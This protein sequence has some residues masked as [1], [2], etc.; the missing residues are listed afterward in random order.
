MNVLEKE[1]H[2]LKTKLAL[3]STD[4]VTD[5]QA[6]IA[7]LDTEIKSKEDLEVILGYL[8]KYRPAVYKRLDSRF[9]EMV[10]K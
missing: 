8:E 5:A 10:V 6:E 3:K 2:L 1:D 9:K 4:T 7:F